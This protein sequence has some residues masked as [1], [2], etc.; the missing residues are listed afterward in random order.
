MNILFEIADRDLILFG[1]I[2]TTVILLGII[3]FWAVKIGRAH[4]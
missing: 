1:F 4:V 2:L 3:I